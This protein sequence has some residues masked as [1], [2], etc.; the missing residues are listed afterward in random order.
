MGLLSV[1]LVV[2]ALALAPLAIVVW[3]TKA[4]PHRP[5]APGVPGR[6]RSAVLFATAAALALGA[7]VVLSVRSSGDFLLHPVFSAPA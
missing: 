5:G 1:L 7:T 2:A 3:A 4:R 6:G